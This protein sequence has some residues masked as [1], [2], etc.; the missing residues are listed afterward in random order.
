MSDGLTDKDRNDLFREIIKKHVNF[1]ALYNSALPTTRQIID[2]LLAGNVTQK[3]IRAA[4]QVLSEEPGNYS[5]LKAL[6]GG[7]PMPFIAPQL[8]NAVFCQL[9]IDLDDFGKVED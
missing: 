6:A 3:E 1:Q 7:N 8:T 9:E 5:F 4:Q 2:A